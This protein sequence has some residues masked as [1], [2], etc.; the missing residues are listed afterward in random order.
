MARLRERVGA[1]RWDGG[2]YPLAAQL[3]ERMMT[4][5]T[6]AEF[7]TLVAYDHID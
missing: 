1:A 4:G 5:E 7:L 2:R 6:F 3:F